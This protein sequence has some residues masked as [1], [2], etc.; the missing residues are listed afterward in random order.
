MSIKVGLV[1]SEDI[2]MVS[3]GRQVFESSDDLAQSKTLLSHDQT[4]YNLLNI[5][6]FL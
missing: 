5:L 3:E 1:F 6:L 2:V 4:L